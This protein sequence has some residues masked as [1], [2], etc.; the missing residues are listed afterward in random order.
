[1]AAKKTKP[2][3]KTLKKRYALL[4]GYENCPEPDIEG[5]FDSIAAVIAAVEDQGYDDDFEGFLGVLTPD[6]KLIPLELQHK[7]VAVMK[8]RLPF[9]KGDGK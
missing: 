8:P 5:P 3:T 9:D 7:W 2:E 1:M 6:Y 4:I